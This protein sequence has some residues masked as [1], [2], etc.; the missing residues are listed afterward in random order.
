[1]NIK[2]LLGA[3]A[4]ALTTA[5]P[6]AAVPINLDFS[7]GGVSGTF[8]GLDNEGGSPSATTATSYDFSGLLDN[9]I[10]IDAGAAFLNS[11]SFED[12]ELIYAEFFDFPSALGVADAASFVSIFLDLTFGSTNEQPALGGPSVTLLNQTSTFTQHH[13]A[14]V[15]LPASALLLLGGIAGVAGLKRRNKHTA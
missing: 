11:F 14:A 7:F 1:M 5:S 4:L 9:Y 15:P 13:L 10:G 3:A 2:T 8:Y 12:G 6:S